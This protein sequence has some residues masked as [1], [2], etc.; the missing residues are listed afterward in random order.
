MA[1][2]EETPDPD[3]RTL[4]MLADVSRWR[5]YEELRLLGDLRAFQLRK[6]LDISELSLAQHLDELTRLKFVVPLNPEDDRRQLLWHARPGGVRLPDDVYD[7]ALEP[8]F[9]EAAREWAHVQHEVQAAMS[10]YWVDV[11]HEHPK[12]WRVAAATNDFLLFLRVEQVDEMVQAFMS[13][14][15]HYQ[16]LSEQNYRD[17][18]LLDDGVVLP[19]IAVANVA[20]HP[21]PP[22]TT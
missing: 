3:A 9:A 19:V 1:P 17:P 16:E 4:R 18:S 8:G 12:D 5:I 22:T 14:G 20:P 15:A 6:L 10:G 2:E 21:K 7:P 11:E 13:L